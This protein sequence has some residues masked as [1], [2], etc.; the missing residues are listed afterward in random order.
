V[1]TRGTAAAALAPK[2]QQ[3]TVETSPMLRLASLK[4]LDET[5]GEST[6]GTRLV[7][8]VMELVTGSTVLLSAAGIYALMAF[9]VA[10]PRRGIGLRIALGAGAPRMLAGVLSR[11]ATQIGVGIAIGIGIAAL[12]DRALDGGW[13]GR[14]PAL[15]LTGVVVLMSA[16]AFAA[17]VRPAREA[18]RIEPTE[19]LRSE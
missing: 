17:A 9:T 6:A 3:L 4:T 18:L 15:V 1:R 8:I 16:I 2:L 14:S 10:R 11:A 19:A 13:T 12:I 7:I 5:V